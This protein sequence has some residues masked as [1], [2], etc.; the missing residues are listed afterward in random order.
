MAV[1]GRS[2][3]LS[4]TPGDDVYTPPEFG[5]P[6]A[7]ETMPSKITTTLTVRISN[8]AAAEVRAIAKRFDI[9]VNEVVEQA[10]QRTYGTA[11][12]GDRDR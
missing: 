5:V 4:V 12:R 7:E 2:K 11:G 10:I 1:N 6:K 9:P 3:W 8:E